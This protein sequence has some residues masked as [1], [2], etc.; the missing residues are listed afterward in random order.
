MSLVRKHYMQYAQHLGRVIR[1]LQICWDPIVAMHDRGVS[2]IAEVLGTDGWVVW[3]PCSR[4][5]AV[6]EMLTVEVLDAATLKRLHTFNTALNDNP[7][8]TWLSF[9]PDSRFLTGF[10]RAEHINW[11]LQTGG[12]VNTFPSRLD[13]TYMYFI[14][15][16]YSTD[17]KMVAVAYKVRSDND[18]FVITTYDLLSGTQA[19]SRRLSEGRIVTPI[20]SHGECLRFCTVK[21]GYITIWEVTFTLTHA[22]TEIEVFPAPDEAYQSVEGNLMFIPTLSRLAFT[23]RGTISVWDAKTS[24]LLL[25][26]VP[27]QTSDRLPSLSSDGRFLAFTSHPRVY[28]YIWKE[29]LNDYS[30]HEKL[31]FDTDH[32]YGT[33]LLSPNGESVIMSIFQTMYLWHTKDPESLHIVPTPDTRLR[34]HILRFSPDEKLV[35]LAEQGE[36]TVRVVD[37]QHGHPRLVINTDMVVVSLGVTWNTVAVV[38]RA[39]VITWNLP[40]W[41]LVSPV[42]VGVEDSVNIISFDYSPPRR[43]L[44]DC[45]HVL[46]SPNLSRIAIMGCF[47]ETRSLGVEIYDVPTEKSLAVGPG[48][49]TMDTLPIGSWFTPD[50]REVWSTYGAYGEG[51]RI[52]QDEPDSAEL[53][54]LKPTAR[55]RGVFPW[56]SRNGYE[57]RDDGWVVSPTKELLFWLPRHWRSRQGNTRTWSGRFLGLT[58]GGLSDAVILEFFG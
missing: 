5:V 32:L 45:R 46:T 20:W 57:I 12:R 8:V 1:G 58:H 11:D 13:E 15:S 25:Q 29:S 34:N 54:S 52:V 48:L 33:P 7:T 35:A 17:G 49:A 19:G 50:G 3:S 27:T 18:I 36:G 14:S 23:I 51:W 24:K 41:N 39:R 53:K 56:E 40:A 37:L 22:P 26:K 9:S 6:K 2:S 30:Q 28:V 31:V 21:P 47:D 38:D 44:R 42:N 4:L 16:T 43:Y 10:G 55:P